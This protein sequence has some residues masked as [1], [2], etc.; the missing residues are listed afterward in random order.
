MNMNRRKKINELAAVVRQACGRDVP[1]TEEGLQ[2]MVKILGGELEFVNPSKMKCEAQIEKTSDSSFRISLAEDFMPK[3]KK[4]SIA[5]E[6]GHLFLHMGFLVDKEK[7]Q[8]ES[9]FQDSVRYRFGR[10]LEEFEANEFAGALLMPEDDFRIQAEKNFKDGKYQ[11]ST[12]AEF[13]EVSGE[14]ALT[15]GRWLGVFPWD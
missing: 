8:H 6:L 1:L 9:L 7:W 5:H 12:I 10:S 14:A 3:R 13:F 4:F 11:V 2:D 15:R